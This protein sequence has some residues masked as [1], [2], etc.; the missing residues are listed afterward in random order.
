M[1]TPSVS[2]V[3]LTPPSGAG[4]T[5]HGTRGPPGHPCPCRLAG[6]GYRPTSGAEGGAGPPPHNGVAAPGAKSGSP[7]PLVRERPALVRKIQGANPGPPGTASRPAR[8]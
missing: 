3:M 2:A 7:P 8:G 5:A 4:Q 6:L 1:S